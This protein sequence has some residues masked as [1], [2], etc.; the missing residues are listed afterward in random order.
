MRKTSPQGIAAISSALLLCIISLP[1]RAQQ[2]QTVNTESELILAL[3]KANKTPKEITDIL[4]ANTSLVTDD[5]W[6]LL[7]G[8]AAQKFYQIPEQSFRLYDLAREVS[9]QLKDE[10]RL[11]KTYYN[12]ARS[13]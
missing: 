9:L 11:A 5:L 7:M 2:R 13:H 6:E 4:H 3:V 1:L 12:I 10:K 8:M